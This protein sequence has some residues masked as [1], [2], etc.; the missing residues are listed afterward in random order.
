M[1]SMAG[2]HASA[3]VHLPTKELF[4]ITAMHMINRELIPGRKNKVG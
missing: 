4:L 1:L 3:W 2:V